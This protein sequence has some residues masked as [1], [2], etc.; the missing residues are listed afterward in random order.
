[1]CPR[2]LRPLLVCCFVAVL[3]VLAAIMPPI[4]KNV[5]E[6]DPFLW[7]GVVVCF[8][9]SCTHE[10]MNAEV[11]TK[12]IMWECVD[13]RQAEAALGASGD[14]LK[15]KKLP[16]SVG[17][18]DLLRPIIEKGVAYYPPCCDRLILSCGFDSLNC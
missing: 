14:Q 6:A 7:Q 5:P 9:L 10:S 2:L 3:A 8:P 1:M 16:A 17:R 13:C 12:Y 4:R 11:H 18:Y 15:K